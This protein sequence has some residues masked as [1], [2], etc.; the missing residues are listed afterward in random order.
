M[1]FIKE[2]ASDL[3]PTVL[4]LLA[5]ALGLATARAGLDNP[6]STILASTA[7]FCLICSAYF[8]GGGLWE[9]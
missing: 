6:A 7:L 5:M 3:L 9:R 8:W 1:T 2:L 4:I